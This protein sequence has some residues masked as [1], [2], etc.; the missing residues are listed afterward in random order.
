MRKSTG[1]WKS[2]QKLSGAFGLRDIYQIP[3]P[4]K[5]LAALEAKEGQGD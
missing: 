1:P 3:L 2:V 4:L 5:M